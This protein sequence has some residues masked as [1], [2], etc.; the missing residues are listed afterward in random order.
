MNSQPFVQDATTEQRTHAHSDIAN[1]LYPDN[2]SPHAVPTP[3]PPNIYEQCGTVAY[4]LEDVLGEA[5]Q[6]FEATAPFRRQ[7]ETVGVIIDEAVPDAPTVDISE[8]SA[9]LSNY[10]RQLERVMAVLRE[11][12]N[13]L[14]L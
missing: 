6:L 12:R 1:V 7:T 11:T 10:E 4:K 8:F 14:A 2:A 3:G 9:V 5:T 13:T